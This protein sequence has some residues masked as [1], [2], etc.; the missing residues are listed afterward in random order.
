MPELATSLVAAFRKQSEI[1]L[2]NIVGSN[3]FNILGI[4]G[5]TAVITPIPVAERFLAFDLP[6]LIGASLAFAGL[7]LFRP[8][9][10]RVAGLGLLAAYGLYVWSAQ[11]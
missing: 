11:G 9:I 1:A 6:V 10:G 3:V 2:G 7:L 4:L 5:L 8:S